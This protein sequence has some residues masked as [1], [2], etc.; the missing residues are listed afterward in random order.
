[1]FDIDTLDQGFLWNSYMIGP[2]VKFR[3]HLSTHEREALDSSRILTSAIRGFAL[4][5][6][7]P[8]S[9]SPIRS[10][11]TGLPS[12]VTVIS[13]LSCRRAGTRFN[14]R[15]I[16]DDGNVANFVET[17][18]VYWSPAGVCFS[19]VQI[20]GSVPVFWEQ[21][22]GLLPGQQKIQ[23]TRSPEATQPAFDKHFD[24]LEVEY[25]TVHILNLLSASKPG[26]V[27][28]TERYRRHVRYSPLNQVPQEKASTDHHLLKQSD[29]DFHAE[30][31]GP[32]GYEAAIMVKHLIEPAANGFAYYLSEDMDDALPDQSQPPGSSH[33][34]AMVILQQEGVFRTNCLDCLDRTNLIQTIVSKMAIE[35]FLSHRQTTATADFWMRHSSLWA[36]NGDVR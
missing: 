35:L 27:E 4:T 9:S 22:T 19:Y 25:G 11:S 34:R 36:D 14:A 16:D 28:L 15:G 33:R 1:M 12:S 31:K 23:I 20:R 32:G 29:F 18:T 24:A 6:T 7:V 17:E 10:A 3:S 21:A 5:V 26:E 2:L 13:R 30:T 8:M